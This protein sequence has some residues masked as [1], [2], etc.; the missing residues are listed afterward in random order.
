MIV[1]IS[2]EEDESEVDNAEDMIEISSDND[3][4]S[5]NVESVFPSHIF[6]QSCPSCD[7][8]AVWNCDCIITPKDYNSYNY[9]AGWTLMSCARHAKSLALSQERKVLVGIMSLSVRLHV[10]TINPVDSADVS[11]RDGRSLRLR[12][13]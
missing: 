5:G 9:P 7:D 8:M 6:T 12:L 3:I 11:S 13:A 4:D 1:E 2:D 10:A